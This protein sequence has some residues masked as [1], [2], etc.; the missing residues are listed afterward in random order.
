MS[1]QHD[2]PRSG[3]G[4]AHKDTEVL[5]QGE[6]RPAPVCVFPEGQKRED[7]GCQSAWGMRGLMGVFRRDSP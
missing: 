4:G 5:R 6:G 1:L 7:A 2:L 3:G